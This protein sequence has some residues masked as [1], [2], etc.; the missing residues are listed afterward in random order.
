MSFAIGG[1]GGGGGLLFGHLRELEVSSEIKRRDE[2]HEA[3][4]ESSHQ[5]ASKQYQ[6]LED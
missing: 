2:T 6:T 5:D 1:G 4:L 3:V